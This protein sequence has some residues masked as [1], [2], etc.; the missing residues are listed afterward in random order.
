MVMSEQEF[1]DEYGISLAEAH[2]ILTGYRADPCSSE[3]DSIRA[4]LV[5]AT[6]VV[7]TAAPPPPATGIV[8]AL[9]SVSSW[10]Y[11]I[12]LEVNG[13]VWPFWH[14]A[15]FFYQLC[16]LFNTLAFGFSDFLTLVN[17]L[18]SKI[19]Q[20]LSWDYIKSL[21]LGWLP[22]LVNIGDWF[23]NW[24]R[25]VTSVITSWWG[26]IWTNVQVWI[27]TALQWLNSTAATFLTFWNNL[28]PYFQTVFNKVKAEWDNFWKVTVPN[29]VDNFSLET[30]WEGRLKDVNKL[31][32]DKVKDWFPF[33]DDLMKL[34]KDIALFFTS[35]LTWL[36]KKLEDWFWDTEES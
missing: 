11:S 12:Y 14:A 27:S 16:L 29:L 9:N 30:W 22:W 5:D 17:Y 33:Y 28:W 2:R 34:W 36:I 8:G 32:N 1:A 4:I 10:F 20:V 24:W 23:Y 21:I 13:W 18:Q 26:P 3:W 31:I 7:C 6:G 25:N 19:S 35:P 15:P